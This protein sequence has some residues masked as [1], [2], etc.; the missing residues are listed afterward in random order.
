MAQ[1][2]HELHC[3]NKAQR[4][5]ALPC[6]CQRVTTYFTVVIFKSQFQKASDEAELFI[7]SKPCSLV[8]KPANQFQAF[9][10]IPGPADQALLGWPYLDRHVHGTWLLYF[11]N[12]Q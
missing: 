1:N 5:P 6:S 3:L 10:I 8:A 2:L 11:D 7:G 12:L 9:D 4:T